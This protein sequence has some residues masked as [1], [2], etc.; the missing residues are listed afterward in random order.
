MKT[1]AVKQNVTDSERLELLIE[2]LRSYDNKTQIIV[3]L[4]GQNSGRA[5]GKEAYISSG[6][7]PTCYAPTAREALD[8]LM[9]WRNL[10]RKH[11]AEM[12][13]LCL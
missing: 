12:E 7:M 9:A 8:K 6:D 1:K 13:A 10:K 3:T 5:P 4:H 2:L 11:V